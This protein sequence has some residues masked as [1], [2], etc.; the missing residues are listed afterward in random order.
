MLKDK[1]IGIIGTGNMGEA[2]VSGLIGS[3][4]TSPENIRFDNRYSISSPES[5]LTF[6]L[7]SSVD[8]CQILHMMQRELQ[9]P[10][11]ARLT[12]S[13]LRG[14]PVNPENRNLTLFARSLAVVL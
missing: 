11:T 12:T 9:R 4:S 13:G 3:E 2:L 8:F 1:K 5:S 6:L 10:V 7:E 14:E